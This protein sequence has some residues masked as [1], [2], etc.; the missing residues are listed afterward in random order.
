MQAHELTRKAGDLVAGDR[1]AVHGDKHA[2][3]AN[4]AGLWNAFLD[5]KGGKALT[6]SDVGLMMC[7][8]KIA[9]T[10]GGTVNVDDWVDAIG[11]IAC[12]GEIATVEYKR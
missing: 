3:F 7:L 11:Y 5:G 1:A 10:Q 4:I 8:L 9:R 6:A 2:N 12:S